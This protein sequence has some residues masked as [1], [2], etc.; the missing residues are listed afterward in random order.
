MD[1]IRNAFRRLYRSRRLALPIVLLLAVGIGTNGVLLSL[2]G[3]LRQEPAGVAAPER[4]A[5]VFS[6]DKATS[7]YGYLTLP[8]WRDYQDGQDVF[9]GFAAFSEVDFALRGTGNTEL[10][11]GEVV[12]EGFFSVLGVEALHGRP[13]LPGDE[14]TVVVLG[15]GLWRRALGGDPQIV[16]KTLRMNGESFTVVGIAPEG[17][18]GLDPE[19][20]AAA[21]MPLRASL[22]LRP[23]HETCFFSRGCQWLTGV[24]RLREGVDLAEA[25]VAFVTLGRRVR[26][27][28]ADAFAE[29]L[30]AVEP[31]RF[32]TVYPVRRAASTRLLGVFGAAT[33]LLLVAVAVSAANLFLA[34]TLAR[35]RELAV[36]LALGAGRRRLLWDLGSESV[37]LA[38]LGGGL[39]IVLARVLARALSSQELSRLL[40]SAAEIRPELGFGLAAALLLLA[41]LTGAAAGIPPLVRALRLDVPAVLGSK[42]TGGS[43]HQRRLWN[44]LVVAEVA[45]A[46]VLL[47]GAVLVL[48][49]WREIHD[50]DLGFEPAGVHL[51]TLDA[52][53]SGLGGEERRA[54]QERTLDR[55][56]SLPGVTAASLAATVPLAGRRHMGHM[57]VEGF[58]RREDGSTHNWYGNVVGPGYFETLG[59][60]LLR[61]RGFDRRDTA[62]S[63]RVAVVSRS[64]AEAYWPGGGAVGRS[65]GL[66]LRGVAEPVTVVG[67]AEDS[68]Y[69]RDWQGEPGPHLYLP[70][71][72][73][74]LPLMT[75]RL[76]VK[77]GADV[78]DAVRA[79][80][81]ALAPDVPLGG[82]IS[83]VEYLA[84]TLARERTAV[85]LLGASGVLALVLTGF[86]LYA[87]LAFAVARRTGEIGIRMALGADPRSISSLIVGSGLRLATLGLAVGLTAGAWLGGRLSEVL[88]RV[89]PGDPAAYVQVA[90]LVLAL[91]FAAAVLPAGA[92]ARVDPLASLRRGSES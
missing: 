60:P 10:V 46:A 76:L 40:P 20:P 72:Q 58:E 31:A 92:A 66:L 67:V 91:A 48:R 49:A 73:A 33:V 19:R 8:D 89:R 65:F 1:D 78:A 35:S 27:R 59:I 32:G 52:G 12:T 70:L 80:M 5:A 13:I 68:W 62:T 42:A 43:P 41:V 53:F 61:G 54:L 51:F 88:L 22:V 55:V 16:G 71:A 14:A 23:G 36:R 79:E 63:P 15:H 82:V 57:V 7:G 24:G 29:Y 26:D 37:V 87:A 21:W 18:R 81:R 4:L 90:I 44:G 11:A 50:L 9:L 83:Y 47:F 39:G 84:S 74:P 3:T 30:P 6:Y 75:T 17:F 64:M 77:S 25:G 56:R 34:R 45:M 28:H 2:A 69:Q 38:L 85:I 86:G